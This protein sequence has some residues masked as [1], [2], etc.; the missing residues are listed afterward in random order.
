[1]DKKSVALFDFD[2]TIYKDYSIFTTTKYL[3]EKQILGA[4][5]EAEMMELYGKYR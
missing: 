2:K 3:V 4:V 1:M 5:V